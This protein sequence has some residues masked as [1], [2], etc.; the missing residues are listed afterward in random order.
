MNDITIV[1]E[2]KQNEKVTKLIKVLLFYYA[3]IPFHTAND[4]ITN[5][6]KKLDM[7]TIFNIIYESS[8]KDDELYFHNNYWYS[9]QTSDINEFIS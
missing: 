4:M 3:T 2:I 5:Y 6:I 9:K 1:F 8:T 7:A